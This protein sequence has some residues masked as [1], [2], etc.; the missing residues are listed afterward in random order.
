VIV[1]PLIS[2]QHDQVAS[3]LGHGN[4]FPPKQD[5]GQDRALRTYMNPDEAGYR[6]VL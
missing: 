1:S 4:A 5:P 6:E 2:L 3:L